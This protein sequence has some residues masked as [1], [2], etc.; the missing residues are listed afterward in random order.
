M[1]GLLLLLLPGALKFT[2]GKDWRYIGHA[3]VAMA[4]DVIVTHTTWAVIAGW[5]KRG[6]WT[7]SKCLERLCYEYDNPDR[8]LHIALARKINRLSPTHDHIKAVT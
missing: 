5:P 4:L 8:M 6:E 2:D 3:A 1:T 7:V